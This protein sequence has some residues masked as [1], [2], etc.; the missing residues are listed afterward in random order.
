MKGRRYHVTLRRTTVETQ[1]VEYI[2]DAALTTH[3]MQVK[4]SA[5]YADPDRWLPFS[6]G[7]VE[8]TDLTSE[9]ITWEVAE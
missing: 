5:G 8:V 6:G 2:A 4:V 3:D 7:D 9:L 1:I